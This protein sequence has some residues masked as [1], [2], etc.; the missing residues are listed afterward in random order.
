MTFGWPS[1]CLI[2]R[3]KTAR[4]ALFGQVRAYAKATPEWARTLTATGQRECLF[5]SW[6]LAPRRRRR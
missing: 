5:E 1:L 2:T 4:E 6:P 3:G